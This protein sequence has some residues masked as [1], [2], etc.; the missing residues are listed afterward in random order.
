MTFL[1]LLSKK[2]SQKLVCLQNG[3]FK[4]KELTPGLQYYNNSQ[5]TTAPMPTTEGNYVISYQN[6][7]ITLAQQPAALQSL[8][9]TYFQTGGGTLS[10][11]TSGTIPYFTSPTTFAALDIPSSSGIYILNV[12][13]N[14]KTFTKLTPAT[15]FADLL[16]IEGIAA[17]PSFPLWN[18]TSVSSMKLPSAG[19][20][21]MQKDSNGYNWVSMNAKN[22][23]KHCWGLDS[24][25]NQIVMLYGGDAK[26][27]SLPST[28]GN[29]LLS[30]GT[31]GPAL[32]ATSGNGSKTFKSI[33]YTTGKNDTLVSCTLGGK[34]NDNMIT[35]DDLTI[36]MGKQYLMTVDI[37]LRC[38]DYEA[39]LDGFTSGNEPLIGVYYTSNGSNPEYII[40]SNVIANP[41]PFIHITGNGI[42]TANGETF[43]LG[44]QRTGATTISH[45][46]KRLVVRL[47][48]L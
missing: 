1:F 35:S 28:E 4:K 30:I 41:L 21:Y 25:K 2:M 3:V 40:E 6:G 12:Q 26:G 33:H 7:A 48:E 29:Y 10:V 22:I 13:T 24:N 15:I 20:W 45:K 36:E 42:F 14:T 5:F 39:V 47:V 38:S 37:D 23:M 34:S 8:T 46:I 32:V 44:I 17:Q 18:G 43:T 11:A 31:S 16:N 27:L 9:N 19:S